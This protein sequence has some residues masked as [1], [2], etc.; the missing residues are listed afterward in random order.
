M[1]HR[2]ILC[3]VL[4]AGFAVLACGDDETSAS[5]VNGSN[6]S[7]SS[8]GIDATCVAVCGVTE[9]CPDA[10]PIT[11]GCETYC[12]ELEAANTATGCGDDFD[13]LISCRAGASDVCESCHTEEATWFACV[14]G[15]SGGA[16]G[17]G[18]GGAGGS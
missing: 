6:G 1:N 11:D 18:S 2:I 10:S 9:D 8:G 15:G 16:G 5:N 4:G 13:A 12:D 17:A 14:N 3:A 7:T